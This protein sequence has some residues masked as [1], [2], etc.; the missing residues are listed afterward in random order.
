MVFKSDKEM[1]EKMEKDLYT[2]VCSDVLDELGYRNQAMRH[3]I[4]PIDSESILVGR[5]K[6]ILSVD[7]YEIYDNPYEGEIK[8]IDSVKPG[9][10]VVGATNKSILN[11]LWGE[12]LSTATKV[13]GGRGAVIDGFSRDVK[14]I[15]K[16]GNF[17]VFA[18]GFKPVDS[19]GRGRL[20]DYD[21]PIMCGDIMVYPG[22][23]IFGDYDGVIVIPKD[24]AEEVVTKAL[25]KVT[26]EDLTRDMLFK[27]QYLADAYAKYGVL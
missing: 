25:E 21:C 16:L 12:L 2:A 9:E 23:L 27:G 18:V 13:R 22:D 24:I 8:A 26:K 7:I 10:V 17:P 19:A 4:R 20:I 1:F 5:A 3:D 15:M 6:T 11:G 14:K